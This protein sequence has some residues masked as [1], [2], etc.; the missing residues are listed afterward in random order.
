MA[1]GRNAKG[2]KARQVEAVLACNLSAL[3]LARYEACRIASDD[4]RRLV[5]LLR[6]NGVGKRLIPKLRRAIKSADGACRHSYGRYLR[7]I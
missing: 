4:L 1:K 7:T 2:L 6:E 5:R 3:E